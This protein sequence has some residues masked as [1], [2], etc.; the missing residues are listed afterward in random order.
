M[1]VSF[2]IVN[3]NS[4]KYLRDCLSSIVRNCCV[5][6]EIWVV[7]NASTDNSI[8]LIND[9]LDWINLIENNKNLGFS[10]ANNIALKNI[11]TE[12]CLFL[13]PDTLISSGSVERLL[14]FILDKDR[15]AIVAPRLVNFDLSLQE[16]YGHFPSIIIEI[17]RLLSLNKLRRRLRKFFYHTLPEAPIE[18]DWVFGACFLGRTSAL[19]EI[20]GFN[21]SFFMYSEDLELCY[22]LR[23]Q[24][25]QI[26]YHPYS[27]VQHFSSISADSEWSS[28]EKYY[29]KYKGYYN[30]L[31]SAYPKIKVKILSL[32]MIADLIKKYF[33]G[34]GIKRE[35]FKKAL[36][37]HWQYLLRE[38]A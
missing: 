17:A 3:Y 20:G 24:N 25:W 35:F 9:Y 30:F 14:E 19:K 7:D 29:H 36:S 21:E 16:S 12:Y 33:L 27:I 8:E 26:W 10:A 32:I 4:G 34:E 13:N 31:Y 28:I 37:Y 6:K 1:F 23:M 15:A 22:R 11:N 38:Q 18:V 2:I 5:D